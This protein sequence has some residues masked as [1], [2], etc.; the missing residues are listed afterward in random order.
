[1]EPDVL[2]ASLGPSTFV[3]ALESL[4]RSVAPV[5]TEPAPTRDTLLADWARIR[6]DLGALEAE[7]TS[8][9]YDSA[10]AGSPPEFGQR[11]LAVRGRLE[12][13]R[14]LESEIEEILA[15]ETSAE[16]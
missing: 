13:L 5:V 6:A 1:V 8:L 16:R 12:A 2:P 14:A 9:A 3:P 15:E 4:G 10:L 7:S 11:L